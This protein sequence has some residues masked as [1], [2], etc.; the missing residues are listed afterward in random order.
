MT[1]EASRVPDGRERGERDPERERESIG[2]LAQEQVGGNPEKQRGSEN[3][4]RMFEAKRASGERG[5]ARIGGLFHGA[6]RPRLGLIGMHVEYFTLQ[7]QAA[8]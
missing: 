3:V 8:Q 1:A 2:S 4:P 7:S 5:L 6:P